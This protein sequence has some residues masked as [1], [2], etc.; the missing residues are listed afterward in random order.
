M[1]DYGKALSRGLRFGIKPKRWLQF[2]ILDLIFLSIG[3]AITISNLSE[4]IPII[5]GY[6]QDLTGALGLLGIGISLLVV[7]VVWM[8]VRLWLM[9]AVVHQSYKEGSRISESFRVAG[10]K[11][12]H[13]LLATV[14]VTVIMALVSMIPYYVGLVITII[15]GWVFFFVIQGI[16]VSGMGFDK[17]IVNSYR[18]FRKSPLEVF[19]AWL[20][21]TIIT[22]VI[23]LVFA[24]PAMV[25]FFGII[26]SLAPMYMGIGTVTP[27]AMASLS[28]T[29]Q[30]NMPAIAVVGIIALIGFAISQAFALKAQT[31]F[32]TQLKKPRK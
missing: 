17:T 5:T 25:L 16:M 4:I 27:D 26:Y 32:Y 1:A 23:Y 11:Y 18:I 8:L 2:F 30:A 19:I 28:Q 3:L 6:S 24:I 9:G 12:L 14:I 29:L 10:R 7:F 21:I 15:L 31:E 20:L 13:I 22:A